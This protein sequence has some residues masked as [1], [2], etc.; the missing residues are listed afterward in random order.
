MNYNEWLENLWQKTKS[1]LEKTAVSC[2][3]IIPY[4]TD[5]KGR[6]IDYYKISPNWWTNGFWGGLMWLMYNETGNEAFKQTA[7]RSEELLDTALSNYELLHHDVGFMFHLTF[8]ADYRITGEKTALNKELFAASTLFSRFNVDGKFIRAWN[9]PEAVGWS[10]VD[11]LMNLPL[12]Y[13]ASDKIGD[14]RFTKVAMHHADMS[15]RDHIRQD[16]SV[17][18]IVEHDLETGEAVK[19][20][21]GQGAF[22]GSCWSRGLAWALYGITLAYIHTKKPEYLDAAIRTANYFCTNVAKY[23]YKTP[24]DFR[25]PKNPEYYDST[26]GVCAACGL[27]ELSKLVSEAEGEA[28]RGVAIN[29]LKA[30]EENFCNF[31]DETD[32]IVGYGSGRY[33]RNEEEIKTEVHLPIIYADFFFTESLIK[34]KGTDFL[35]W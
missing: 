35:I 29:V 17:N 8:G 23:D 26:A 15:I 31:T 20:Y 12:L 24:I 11:C 14:D 18:H 5:E 19:F 22:E 21:A 6:F 33:P 30:T 34:L 1:K 13:F 7:R 27:L 28:Y 25:Q 9:Q 3:D 2:R 10:I 4:T 32:Y 16:G